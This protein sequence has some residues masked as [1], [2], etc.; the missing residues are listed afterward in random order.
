MR[1]LPGRPHPLGASW[2]AAGTQ[3]ALYSA[4]ATRV[5]LC[6]FD[7]LAATTP[8]ARLDLA[9]RTQ[10]VWHALLPEVAPGQL[11]GYR[12]HGPYAPEH[13]Q[14]CNPAKLLIDPYA[15]AIAG[16]VRHADALRGGRECGL[17]LD[18]EPDPRD[19]AACVPRSLVVDPRFD[20]Q[21]DRAP[22]TPWSRTLVYE[23]SV[24]GMTARHPDVAPELRGTYLGL[25]SE[26][27]IEH[28]RGLGVSAVELL[29]VQHR[30]SEAALVQRGL[31]NYWGY[32]TLGFFAPDARFATRDRGEQVVEFKTMVQ[33]L[34]RAGIEVW[35]D[36]VYNHTAEGGHDGPTLAFRGI[37]N[38]AYYR[39]D[40]AR[41][42]AYLDFSGC[43]NA[44]NLPH[45]RALQLVMDSLRYWVS[46]L[47]VDGF[48]FDLAPALARGFEAN[49]GLG[50]F[51]S[52][53]QQDPTLAETKLIAEPWD[54]GEN[55][56]RLGGFPDGWAEWNGKYRDS[57]RRFWRGD[58]GRLG[59]LASRLAGS[60]D[61]YG[62]RTP[63][64]SIN[65]VT[66]HDGF[67]LRDLVSYERKHNEAN[68]EQNRDGADANW[69]SNSG[70][71]GET[72]D[73]EVL[74]LRALLQRNLLA[75]LAF[76]QGVPMLSHGDELG[77]TQRGNNNAYCHD[78]PLSWVDWEPDAAGRELLA[79][80][81]RVFAL[82]REHPVLRRMGFFSGKPD[83]AG[84]A[85]DLSWLRPDGSELDPADWHDAERRQLGMWMTCSEAEP[86]ARGGATDSLLLLLNA[87]AADCYFRL[88][89]MPEPG[90]FE[91]L[92]ATAGAEL[93]AGAA[94][95]GDGEARVPARS[96]ALLA[97]R[98]GARA[99]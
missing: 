57:L 45:P 41:P 10:N 77:R 92:L 84:L 49:D 21:D 12:V 47:H 36:V 90:R 46:E 2:T 89:P 15:R 53:V 22:L 95:R 32:N 17:E 87:A 30:I 40:P 1:T 39:L 6:L 68:G 23:C 16:D 70:V 48:R 27:V 31:S 73:P 54:L 28:L 60:E 82:R 85:K 71:E 51:F 78:G 67:T 56:Y 24:K 93:C 59:K 3:F 86:D 96:L 52:L 83:A 29:P 91:I 88:P 42:A 37:D 58:A 34:H 14:R 99:R 25:A 44:F 65:F 81:Q 20:W 11:Y 35:L 75:S 26:P 38:A 55:G 8:S 64:A 18:R 94:L 76:S 62:S 19:D 7:S 66:C 72:D 80:A 50:R 9:Q 63:H 33:R 79:F 97:A 4:A 98:S 74:A 13:G 61:F 5:E 43:G 69:S